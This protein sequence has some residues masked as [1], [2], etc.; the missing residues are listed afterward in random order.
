[1]EQ[2]HVVRRYRV[3]QFK[4]LYYASC[5]L[6]LVLFLDARHLQSKFYLVIFVEFFDVL[7][8][9]CLSQTFK[10]GLVVTRPFKQWQL[11]DLE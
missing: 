3:C 7:D 6:C 9:V 10:E 2:H 4:P 5:A 1:M 8:F 11:S